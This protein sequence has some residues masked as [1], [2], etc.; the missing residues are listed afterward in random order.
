MKVLRPQARLGAQPPKAALSAERRAALGR[1]KNQVC[2]VI[3]H[4]GNPFMVYMVC[5]SHGRGRMVAARGR[6]PRGNVFGACTRLPSFVGE[7]YMPPGRGVPHAGFPVRCPF[8]PVC[9]AGV[10][11]RRECAAGSR[12]RPTIW[13]THHANHEWSVP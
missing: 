5:I 12:P 3:E 6:L 10:H 7:A 1:K 8:P 4:S 2:G 13:V 11:A 9:R